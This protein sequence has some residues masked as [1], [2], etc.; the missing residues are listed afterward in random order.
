MVR[1][2][3]YRGKEGGINSFGFQ[4]SKMKAYHTEKSLFNLDQNKSFL[5]KWVKSS[6]WYDCAYISQGWNYPLW[7]HKIP[8]YLE[9]QIE[10]FEPFILYC[11]NQVK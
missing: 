11:H 2:K 8:R 7:R 5:E 1:K 3:R 4:L 6:L 10:I 9:E